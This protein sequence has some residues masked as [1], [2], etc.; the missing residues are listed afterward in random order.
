MPLPVITGIHT[1]GSRV[2]KKAFHY[3]FTTYMYLNSEQRWSKCRALTKQS[4]AKLIQTTA[5]TSISN[6]PPI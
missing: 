1:A 3:I 5:V 4:A 6:Y 2:N